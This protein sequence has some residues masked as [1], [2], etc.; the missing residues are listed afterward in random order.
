MGKDGGRFRDGA[1]HDIVP[2]T[3]AHPVQLVS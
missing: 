3:V 1:S 2:S